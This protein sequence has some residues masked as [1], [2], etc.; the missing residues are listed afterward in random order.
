MT[1]LV[2]IFAGCEVILS[3]TELASRLMGVEIIWNI[4]LK[5]RSARP[6]RQARK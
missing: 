4:L 5:G 1:C 3:I 2:I 6:R